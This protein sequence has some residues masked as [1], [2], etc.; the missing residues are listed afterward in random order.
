MGKGSQR[1]AAEVYSPMRSLDSA[2]VAPSRRDGGG[3]TASAR[4]FDAFESAE[5]GQTNGNGNGEAPGEFA[6]P[7]K[8]GDAVDAGDGAEV[9][10]ATDDT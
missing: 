9:D 2:A 10:G 8:L 5:A 7:L 1:S 6:N 4:D 3:A